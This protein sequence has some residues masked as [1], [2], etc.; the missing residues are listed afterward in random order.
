MTVNPQRLSERARTALEALQGKTFNYDLELAADVGPASGWNVR[1]AP[2]GHE[3]IRHQRT[4]P[5]PDWRIALK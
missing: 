5:L 2:S 4:T 1:L 3:W